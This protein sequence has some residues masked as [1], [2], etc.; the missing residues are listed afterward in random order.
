MSSRL[1]V[2][3]SRLL[4]SERHSDAVYQGLVQCGKVLGRD[5]VLVHGACP[6]GNRAR[7]WHGVR[8]HAEGLDY[9]AE[10]WWL[11]WRLPVD[12]HPADWRREGLA[13]GP[14]RNQRMVDTMDQSVPC[15]CMAWPHPDPRERSA[16]TWDCVRRAL[17]AGLTVLDGWTLL[18]IW[19]VPDLPP[20]QPYSGPMPHADALAGG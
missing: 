18:P 2:T 19:S 8:V 7:N 16:G 9:L 12:P 17:A 20:S 6:P 10:R 4:T 3:G 5:T 13:A 14:N 15:L 1:L 11:R